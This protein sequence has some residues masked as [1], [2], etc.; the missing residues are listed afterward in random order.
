MR[1]ILIAHLL[2]KHYPPSGFVGICKAYITQN[3]PEFMET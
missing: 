1:K 2:T 3:T